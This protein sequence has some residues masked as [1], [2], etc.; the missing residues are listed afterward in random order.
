MNWTPSLGWNKPTPQHYARCKAGPPATDILAGVVPAS[1][2]DLSNL[3][4]IIDQLALGSCTANSAAQIIHAAMV[5]AGLDPSTP[6]FSRLFVYFMARLEAGDQAVDAGSQNCT[7][8]DAVCRMGF[9]PESVWP[10]DIAKF[11]QQPPME[12][13]WAA[14]DQ[15][16]KVDVNYHRIDTVSGPA[17]LTVMKQALT[18]GYLF[19]FAGPVTNAFCSGQVGTTPDN[20]AMPPT[21][22]RNI[23]GGHSM[24]ACGYDD[25]AAKPFFKIVNSWGQNFGDGGFCYFA[26]SYLTW[27]QVEDMWLVQAVIRYSGGAS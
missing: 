18:A 4:K 22:G 14:F 9:C 12:A 3:V 1:K 23:A 21:D 8:I 11:A 5:T 7:V 16:G 13:V 10:Y 6:F 27:D 17:L 24:T 15:R 20:P 25:T 2:I 19:N 26:P